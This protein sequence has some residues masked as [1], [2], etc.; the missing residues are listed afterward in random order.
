MSQDHRTVLLMALVRWIDPVQSPLEQGQ[1]RCF[2]WEQAQGGVGSIAAS[3]GGDQ[4]GY[5]PSTTG[6]GPVYCFTFGSWNWKCSCL[7]GLHV[8][9]STVERAVF[10]FFSFSTFLTANVYYCSDF[11]SVDF[12]HHSPLQ[13]KLILTFV[14]QRSTRG[15]SLMAQRG[16]RDRWPSDWKTSSTVSIQPQEKFPPKHVLSEHKGPI[17]CFISYIYS[18]WQWHVLCP[19]LVW[20]IRFQILAPLWLLY[21]RNFIISFNFLLDSRALTCDKIISEVNGLDLSPYISPFTDGWKS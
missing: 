18:R 16:W 21:F 11:I 5:L 8:G 7:R 20:A 13:Y 14:L 2:A 3:V 19:K 17:S 10:R 4:R 1:V 6:V 9:Y 12:V 15:W